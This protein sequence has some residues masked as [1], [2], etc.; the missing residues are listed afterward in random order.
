MAQEKKK[1]TPKF[2]FVIDPDNCMSC[3]ACEVECR[4]GAVYID[5]NVNYAISLEKCN[6]CG[7]CYRACPVDAISKNP[8]PDY[9]EAS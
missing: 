5:E 8:N 9:Q 1:K 6:R 3:A 4:F 2:N 7:R